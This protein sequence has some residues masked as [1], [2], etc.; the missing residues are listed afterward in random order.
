MNNK[1]P[2]TSDSFILRRQRS[3]GGGKEKGCHDDTVER[4]PI[5]F[6]S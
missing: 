2:D 4:K 3:K 6:S 5:A 1:E